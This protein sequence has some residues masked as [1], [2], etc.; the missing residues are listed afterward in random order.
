MKQQQQD[1]DSSSISQEF[2]YDEMDPEDF[3]ARFNFAEDA[4]DDQFQQTN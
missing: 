1:E 2:E 4:G 3:I